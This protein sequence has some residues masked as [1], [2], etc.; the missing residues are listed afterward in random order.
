MVQVLQKPNSIL[1]NFFH[2]DVDLLVV[3][4]DYLPLSG[5]PLIIGKLVIDA[6]CDLQLL[7]P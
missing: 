1:Q 4:C 7:E 6:R 5:F 2:C 3:S